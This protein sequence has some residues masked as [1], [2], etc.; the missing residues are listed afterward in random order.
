MLRKGLSEEE[1]CEEVRHMDLWGKRYQAENSKYKG[2][3]VGAYLGI[4][5]T[6]RGPVCLDE[7]RSGRGGEVR[8]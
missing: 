7:G 3:E 4:Q 8:I 2:P 5:E 6:P 1:M